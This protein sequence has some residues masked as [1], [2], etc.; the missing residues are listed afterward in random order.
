LTDDV[1]NHFSQDDNCYD[2]T[3]ITRNKWQEKIDG[4]TKCYR[5]LFI[6][7]TACQILVLCYD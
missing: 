3:S 2:S 4:V 1:Y 5:N 6:I 7:R